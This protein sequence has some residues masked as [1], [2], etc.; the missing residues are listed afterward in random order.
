MLCQELLLF[1]S[2]AFLELV[3]DLLLLVLQLTLQVEEAF[4]NVLH[5]LELEALQLL[6]NLFEQLAVFVV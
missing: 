1:F 3:L 5:L 6:L 4:V 2:E